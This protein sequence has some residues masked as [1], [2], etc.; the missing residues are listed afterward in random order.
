MTPLSK[1]PLGFFYPRVAVRRDRLI[2]KRRRDSE[3]NAEHNEIPCCLLYTC[4]VLFRLALGRGV[5]GKRAP[6]AWNA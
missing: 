1:I 2:L 6:R 4:N 3:A 5:S